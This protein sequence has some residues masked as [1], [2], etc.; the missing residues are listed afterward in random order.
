MTMNPLE[1]KELPAS[2]PEQGCVITLHGRGTSGEDLMPIADEINLPHLRFLFP[3]APFPFPD[4][5]GGMMWY[6]GASGNS[7]GMQTSRK[8]LFD[9]LD[10]I[11]NEEHIPPE[12]IALLGFSQ[13]AVMALDVGL[14][15]PK[16]IGAL[17]ALSGFLAAPDKLH[18]EQSPASKSV[19]ILLVHGTGDGVVSVEG[20]REARTLL[21]E[22]GYDVTLKEYAMAHQIIPEEITLIRE[23]LKSHLGLP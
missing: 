1:W 10:Q 12:N 3:D 2:D 13:G 8:L 4:L 22:E 15:Y 9:L 21:L 11:I 5:L 23:H 16:K 14:R 20:S 17:I 18:Q 19:P 7:S 6:G